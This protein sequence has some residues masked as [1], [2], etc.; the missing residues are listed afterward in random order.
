[1]HP[2]AAPLRS[3][4]PAGRRADRIGGYYMIHREDLKQVLP[5]WMKYTERVRE[6]AA[7]SGSAVQ[8]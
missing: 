5:L 3:A 4:G 2:T 1:M 6:D 8:A 7:V